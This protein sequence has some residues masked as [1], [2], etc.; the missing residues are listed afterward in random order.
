MD[1][2]RSAL[3]FGAWVSIGAAAAVVVTGDVQ[4]KVMTEVQ[5]MKM[6][7][8]EALYTTEQPAALSV[9][10]V[11]TLDGSR[12]VFALK[13]PYVLSF[14]GTGD[15][16]GR[17]EGINDLQARYVAEFGPGSYTPVI[18]VTY[19]SFRLMIGFGVLAALVA[20]WALWAHRGGRTPGSPWLARAGLVLPL[21]PLA[22]NAFGWIFTEMGRQ[23]W[24]VFGEMLT[25]DG[26]SR[27]VS[28]GEVLTSFTAFTLI[29]ATLAVVE[30]RLLLR[31]ARAGLPS[32]DRL[33]EEE[34]SWKLSGSY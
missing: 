34:P 7:A 11:G 3:R 30:V 20:A 10:T 14:L 4:G 33:P 8:A 22:A 29:Y 23:P 18:P 32:L 27:S 12:E 6:A 31:Y 1:T 28:L 17:V 9:F 15:V 26:V 19:W 2:H 25:R 24:V 5:P 21:L 13:V 16:N